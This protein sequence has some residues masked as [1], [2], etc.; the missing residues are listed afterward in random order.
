MPGKST[1]D[2]KNFLYF[3]DR[4]TFWYPYSSTSIEWG[5]RRVVP[6][7]AVTTHAKPHT[8]QRLARDL[9]VE[10][11]AMGQ[12]R[13]HHSFGEVLR[14]IP[15][16]CR[17]LGFLSIYALLQYIYNKSRVRACDLIPTYHTEGAA[18]PCCRPPISEGHPISGLLKL[19]R[20]SV[21]CCTTLQAW[22]PVCG[23]TLRVSQAAKTLMAARGGRANFF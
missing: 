7:S 18:L 8:Q 15:Q 3:P 17:W 12:R 14:G 9:E 22:S 11:A 4:V 10:R 20:P 16:P 1:S 21:R 6:A 5:L 13:R 2:Y 19:G 23:S